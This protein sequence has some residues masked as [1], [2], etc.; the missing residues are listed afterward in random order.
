[1]RRTS[2]VQTPKDASVDLKFAGCEKGMVIIMLMR[3][4][5]SNFMSF[6]YKT[7]ENGVAI[8]AE[9]HLYAGRTEQ[10]K[11]RVIHY[12]ERKVLKF[13][14]IYGANASGKTNLIRA[15]DA[16]KQIVLNTM[17][18]VEV[19]D[20]FCRSNRVNAEAPTLF[21]YEFTVGDRCFAYGFTVNLKDNIVLSEWLYEMKAAK[22]YVIFERIVEKEQYYFDEDLFGNKENREQF[23]F[24]IKDANRIN[25]TLLLH[26]IKRRKIDEDDFDIFNKIY[27]WFQYKLVVIYPETKIGA[28]YF[29]F[30]SDNKK[31]VNI[32]K[33]LDTGITDY[34]MRAMNEA[35]FKE[36]FSDESL[37]EKFLRKPDA[38][39]VAVSRSILKFGNALFELE[40]DE[41][42]TKKI[43]KLMFQHGMDESKYEYGEESD[44]TQRLIELL[45]VILNDEEDKTFIIDE[46]NRSLHPQMTIKFVETFLK[47]SEKKTTQLIITT[48]ESNLMDLNILRRDEIWFAE[49]EQD[50]S[51]S[52][53]TLEKFKIRYDKVVAK[54]YLA[55]RY[56]A[57]PVFKDFEYVWGKD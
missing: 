37:A 50:N 2:K 4:S 51:T 57:V 8:P 15:I 53:Y 55:G 20:K 46:L 13:S 23:H 42:G 7:D 9:Y 14:S 28:S 41:T 16:G 49:K 52:L 36:Y 19:Q 32:L 10:H 56:G 45:D 44:G 40:Y 47:F 24:F 54:D 11:E 33:Y 29:L 26:E 30:G 38:R 18:G 25:T 34:S 39:K 3:F 12:K 35:A 6:G 43:A 21:E 5:I 27:D 22:E 17:E 31:L 1:M 48:H